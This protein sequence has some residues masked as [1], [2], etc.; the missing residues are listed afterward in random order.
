MKSNNFSIIVNIFCDVWHSDVI[1]ER[2]LRKS[3]FEKKTADDE[4]MHK[5]LS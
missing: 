4:K 3:N 1:L 2:N 5:I